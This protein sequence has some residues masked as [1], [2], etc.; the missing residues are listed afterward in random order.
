[1]SSVNLD[2]DL[3]E[4][5]C[6][7]GIAVTKMPTF[8]DNLQGNFRPAS[9]FSPK[10]AIRSPRSRLSRMYEALVLFAVEGA[11]W[12]ICSAIHRGTIYDS[13]LHATAVVSLQQPPT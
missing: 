7:A 1:D 2:A 9:G 10:S 8:S 3:I 5:L 4:A 12:T 13:R 11:R 6:V